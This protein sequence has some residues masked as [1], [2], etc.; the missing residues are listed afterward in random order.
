MYIKR[1]KLICEDHV[2][3]GVPHTLSDKYGCTGGRLDVV[4]D[5]SRG[6]D[7]KGSKYARRTRNKMK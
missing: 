5:S 1:K 4:D 7:M 6:N 3:L 2:C